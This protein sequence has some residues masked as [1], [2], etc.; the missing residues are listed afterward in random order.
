MRSTFLFSLCDPWKQ[1]ADEKGT[2]SFYLQM[3]QKQTAV[4]VEESLTPVPVFTSFFPLP[5][6]S[7]PSGYLALTTVLSQL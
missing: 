1:K 7:L 3:Q 4:A 6:C 5:C 2:L